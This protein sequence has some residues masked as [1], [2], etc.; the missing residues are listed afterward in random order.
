MKLERKK[1]KIF[2]KRKTK[3]K[4]TLFTEQNDQIETRTSQPEFGRE[5]Q[6][7]PIFKAR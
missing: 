7:G 3:G 2:F 1:T 4:K 5:I 6:N